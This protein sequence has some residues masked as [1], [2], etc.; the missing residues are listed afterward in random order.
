MIVAFVVTFI[1][2]IVF[3]FEDE[4]DEENLLENKKE[5]KKETTIFSPLKGNVVSLKEVPD[6]V[7][8]SEAMGKGIAI[9]PSEGKV[10]SPVNG[11]V[12]AIFPTLHAI[13]I[14]SD[15][16]VEI[17]IH[18]GLDTVN[19]NGKYYSS[20]VSVGDYVHIGDELIAF[21]KQAIENEGYNT[22][23]PMIITNSINFESIDCIKNNEVNYKDEL[24]IIK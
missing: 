4:I 10:V 20:K 6:E 21:D 7:F 15:T 19:L 11:E 1:L 18:I 2:T 17:L 3:G 16:G 22:I 24:L 5:V 14:T 9:I 13:G 8:A 12:T 23:T